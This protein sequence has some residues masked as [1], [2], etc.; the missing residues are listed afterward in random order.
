MFCFQNVK[1]LIQINAAFCWLKP[2]QCWVSYL[3]QLTVFCN[4]CNLLNVIQKINSTRH[5]CFLSRAKSSLQ[6]NKRI[7]STLEISVSDAQWARETELQS[8]CL[9]LYWLPE[10]PLAL[11]LSSERPQSKFMVNGNFAAIWDVLLSF[12]EQCNTV[13]PTSPDINNL[14]NLINHTQT[15]WSMCGFAAPKNKLAWFRKK[16][17]LINLPVKSRKR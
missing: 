12:R 16:A 5:S 14:T 1:P 17:L 7:C 6:F 2:A 8:I 3:L 4:L 9:G 15:M 10:A 13:N 11:S